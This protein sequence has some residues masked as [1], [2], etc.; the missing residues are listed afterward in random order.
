MRPGQACGWR[1]RP[2]GWAGI[3]L[4]LPAQAQA[5]V[6]NEYRV[7]SLVESALL[8]S[9]LQVQAMLRASS[10]RFLP[11]VIVVCGVFWLLLRRRTS[12]HPEPLFGVGA[13]ALGCTLILILFW[14]EAAPVFSGLVRQIQPRSVFSYVAVENGMTRASAD[15]SGLIPSGLRAPF[16]TVP[17][18]LHLTLRMV[19]ETPLVVG[20]AIDPQTASARGLTAPFWRT[21]PMEQFL[22]QE[23][24]PNAAK[25]LGG[26]LTV[27]Y[28]PAVLEVGAQQD[29]T[30]EQIVPWSADM[31]AAMG[32]AF[33]PVEGGGDIGRP[34]QFMRGLGAGVTDVRCSQAWQLMEQDTIR[35]LGSETTEQGRSMGRLYQDALGL[36]FQDQARI[37]LMRQIE[38]L[39]PP[40]VLAPMRVVNAK[41]AADLGSAISNIVGNF[42]PHNPFKSSV[43]VVGGYLERISAF[44]RPAAFLVYWGPY[45][46]GA[47]L[48][49][50][51]SFFPIVLLWS[52]F[53]NQGFKPIVNYFLLLL[54]VCSTPLWWGMVNA[55]AEMSRESGMASAPVAGNVITVLG[56]VAQAQLSYL[57]ITVVGIIMVP[58]LQAILL[59]GSWRAIGG[60]WRG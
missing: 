13:Y 22:N 58:I 23:L 40:E 29:L 31:Q 21:G 16:A 12:A 60:I 26:Y 44:L 45:I 43:G 34:V 55:M 52:M 30:A 41:R 17:A 3:L 42:D 25:M 18:F 38:G 36:S 5:Q 39:A 32:T 46:V 1:F 37:I 35:Y 53:P 2:F 10:L 7:L 6:V 28:N 47:A 48:F 50:I 59:F 33:F 14:P 15:G 4:S 8:W 49:T 24:S 27:C 20:E 56:T 51:V 9:G 54:F 11:Q 57:V 19:T